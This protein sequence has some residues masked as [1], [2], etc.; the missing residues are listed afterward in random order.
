MSAL[1]RYFGWRFRKSPANNLFRMTNDLANRQ[2]PRFSKGNAFTLIELLVVIA[3]IAILAS[4]LLPALARAKWRTKVTACSSNLRQLSLAAIMYGSDYN[5]KLPIMTYGGRLVSQ[6]D[7]AGNW[8]WDM[9]TRVTGLLTQNGAQRHIL[10]DPGFSK[11]DN[12]TLWNFAV[13]GGSGFRVVGYTPTFP[14][15]PRLLATNIN[16]SLSS[17]KSFMVGGVQY[18]PTATERVLFA[19]V[20]ISNNPNRSPAGKNFTSV[21]GGFKGHSTSH[22]DGKMPAGGNLLF[23]DGHNEW[24]KFG[25][26]NQL[27]YMV[28]R[29][30]GG[31][32][33]W[34]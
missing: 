27:Q 22:L 21:D 30:T 29:T 16:D 3:I 14:E 32:S 23:L 33:F 24:R 26:T 6:G 11:Q 34:F 2:T 5:D 19:D 4:L 8:P 12:D 15:T 17:I 1:P 18:S 9:P 13:V 31:P 7:T 28:V 10:Y 25:T 20:V